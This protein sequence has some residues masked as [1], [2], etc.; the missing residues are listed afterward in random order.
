[1]TPHVARV[2]NALGLCV[3]EVPEKPEGN[4]SLYAIKLM[5]EAV[6]ELF[7]Q[8]LKRTEPWEREMFVRNWTKALRRRLTRQ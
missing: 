7:A 2:L 3:M 6:A 1:M 8:S 4:R 5:E